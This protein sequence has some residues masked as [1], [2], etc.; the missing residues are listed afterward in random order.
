M[1]DHLHSPSLEE[2]KHHQGIGLNGSFVI[3]KQ[4]GSALTLPE[5][6]GEAKSIRL[7]LS[8]VVTDGSFP[9]SLLGASTVLIGP[10]F[11]FFS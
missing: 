7:C 4:G 9:S 8:T 11:S 1:A 3:G 10:I 2:K 6:L 5:T